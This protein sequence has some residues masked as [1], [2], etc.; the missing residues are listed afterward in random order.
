MLPRGVEDFLDTLQFRAPHVPHLI[1]A[2]VDVGPQIG[3][4]S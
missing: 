2:A 3:F 1:E 4:L